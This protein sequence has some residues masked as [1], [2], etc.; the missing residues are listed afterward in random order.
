[1]A[2][3]VDVLWTRVICKQPGRY[4]GWPT[5]ARCKTGKLLAVRYA[6]YYARFE[7]NQM[8]PNMTMINV[9]IRT[10]EP[11]ELVEQFVGVVQFVGD[12]FLLIASLGAYMKP[13]RMISHLIHTPT[14]KRRRILLSYHSKVLQ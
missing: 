4:I 10:W 8:A 9:S 12:G 7:H 3:P 13:P 5:I 2:Q 6:G 1:M 14:I 11:E